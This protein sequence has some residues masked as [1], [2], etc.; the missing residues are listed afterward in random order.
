MY[1]LFVYIHV[2]TETTVF[3]SWLL[4]LLDLSGSQS[5]LEPE[6]KNVINNIILKT[7]KITLI[8]EDRDLK[9][10]G[11]Q[12]KK[13]WGQ[14]FILQARCSSFAFLVFTCF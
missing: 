14:M 4:K 13:K 5:R 12:N 6:R 9:F 3:K 11:C 8:I 1:A 2:Y 7:R 10:T